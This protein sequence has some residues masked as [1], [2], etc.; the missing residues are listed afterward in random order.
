M[1]FQ[2]HDQDLGLLVAPGWG[3]VDGQLTSY[4]VIYV[5]VKIYHIYDMCK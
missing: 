2:G 1:V 3:I 5:N 4:T